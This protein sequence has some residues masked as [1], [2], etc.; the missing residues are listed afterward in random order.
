[1]EQTRESL[2]KILKIH[3]EKLR[4][5]LGL[6]FEATD[7]YVKLSDSI[8][9]EAHFV[10][11]NEVAVT[12]KTDPFVAALNKAQERHVFDNK[13]R[14]QE[15][16]DFQ[17]LLE[18]CLRTIPRMFHT[19]AHPAKAHASVIKRNESNRLSRYFLSKDDFEAQHKKATQDHPL[20]HETHFAIDY[21][22]TAIHWKSGTIIREFGSDKRTAEIKAANKLY[23]LLEDPE[24]YNRTEG[25]F[26]YIEPHED[27]I[28]DIIVDAKVLNS[29]EIKTLIQKLEEEYL[30]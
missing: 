16:I 12:I 23:K 2:E 5:K 14:T 24:I 3:M 29:D 21:R 6:K 20:A 18:S 28:Y 17:N 13:V 10:A 8:N 7:Y 27:L 1:M 4:Q 15:E 30:T 26:R 25:N 9:A 19:L 22:C 11:G